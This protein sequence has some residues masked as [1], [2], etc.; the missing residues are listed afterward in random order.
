MTDPSIGP[1]AVPIDAPP[2]YNLVGQEFTTMLSSTDTGGRYALMHWVVPPG[3][4]VGGHRHGPYE[5]TFLLLEGTLEFVVDGEE[6]TAGPGT[7]V[8]APAGVVHAYRNATDATARMLVTFSPGGIEELFEGFAVPAGQAHV[9]TP[10]QAERY[11]AL[12]R[13]AHGTEYGL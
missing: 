6:L 2:E 13:D 11:V 9:P 4:D 10:E 12:A 8:R 3:I 5:E 1:T 7:W